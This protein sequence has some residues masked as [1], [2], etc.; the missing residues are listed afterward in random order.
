MADGYKVQG[1][2]AG[3]LYMGFS[4]LVSG[5]LTYVFQ[6]VSARALGPEGYG[7]LAV[8]WA[9]TFLTV[10]V[11]WIGVSQTLGRYI[12][13]READG[14]SQL[15]VVASVKRLQFWLLAAFV[16]A[17]LLLGP[18]FVGALFG[19]ELFLYAAF[20][21]AVAAYAPEYFRRG[22]FAGQRRFARLGA[23][24]V[25]ESASRAVIAV[26]LLALGAGVVGPT[27]AILAAPVIGVLAVRP[28]MRSESSPA[29]APSGGKKDTSFSAW[30]AFRFA[31]PVILCVA[32]GQAF[33]NGGPLFLSFLGGSREEA[34]LLLAALILTRAPQYVLSPAVSALL[35][36][37]SRTF[38]TGGRRALDRF[39][40]LSVGVVGVAGVFMVGGAW[41]LGEQGMRLL[42][43]P[44]FEA[45][46][47]LLAALAALA[48]L[49]LLCE[50][51]SQALFALGAAKLAAFGWLLG[52]PASA[53]LMALIQADPVQRVSYSLVLGAFVA[54][55]SQ[56]ILY[57]SAR[58]SRESASSA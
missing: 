58:R 11:L 51:V 54:A 45:E 24:H 40:A 13:E 33:L 48:A 12:A 25:V 8:L 46:R 6:S 17:A 26:V 29:V 1:V 14:A 34:G 43:G 41:V 35:P 27:V 52:L 30:G 19:G 44:G 23:L 31:G 50:V 10:Q 47:G 32:C 5:V 2:G 22:L 42:Y 4:F 15:T 20:V 56:T 7:G 16:A 36:H 37:A 57:L 21:L 3:S 28:T 38:A 55:V 49:Y 18:L 9:A 53:I 39:L